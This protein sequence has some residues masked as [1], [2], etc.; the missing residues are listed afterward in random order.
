MR[1]CVFRRGDREGPGIF[2]HA[3]DL[4]QLYPHRT[5]FHVSEFTNFAGVMCRY[6]CAIG[7][8]ETAVLYYQMLKQVAPQTSDDQARQTRTLPTLL[9][10]VATHMGG[11]KG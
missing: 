11:E 10:Q 2:D 4:K 6:F 8:R 3:C 5:R 1:T 7:E 9:G